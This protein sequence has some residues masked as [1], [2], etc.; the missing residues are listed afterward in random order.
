MNQF[1]LSSIKRWITFLILFLGIF[2]KADATVVIYRDGLMYALEESTKTASVAA[3]SDKKSLV[4]VSIPQ[5]I[6]YEDVEY[7]VT[8][9]G[10]SQSFSNCVN[11]E[12]ISFPSTFT[13]ISGY[14]QFGGCTSLKSVHIDDADTPIEIGW[15]KYSDTD[16]SG[17]FLGC[18]IEELY[19]GRNFYF[20]PNSS[21]KYP[22]TTY[23]ERY[24]Y[25][26]F[27][28]AGM[29]VTLGPKVSRIPDNAFRVNPPH[30]LICLNPSGM[31]IGSESIK[32]ESSN[33]HTLYIPYNTTD[34]Y[35][36]SLSQY[37]ST[38][39]E[40]VYD[41]NVIYIPI[42]ENTC[43]ARQHPINTPEAITIASSVEIDAE[44]Y[45]VVRIADG[46]F[47]DNTNLTS[48]TLPSS[49]KEIGMN[50][51]TNCQKLSAIN[52]N[53]QQIIG[54]GAFKDCTSLVSV[55]LPSSLTDIGYN[56]FYNASSITSISFGDNLKNIGNA[57]FFNCAALT[58]IRLPNTTV[59]IGDNAFTNCQKLTYASL[60]N[61][62]TRIGN[63]AFRNC[64]VLTEIDV[65]GTT[66]T[67]GNG[68]FQDCST[69]ALAT[70]H[71]GLKTM[72]TNTFY[73]CK[74]LS[75]I[76]IPGTVTSIGTGSFDQC[77]ALSSVTFAASDS[78]LTIPSFT[79]APLR[80]LRIGR[81][82]QYTYSDTES[83]FRNKST[84]TRVQFTGNY[85]N[86]I[87]HYLLDGC[88]GIKSITL[89]EN[90]QYIRN[91][92]FRGCSSI[93]EITLPSSLESI[94]GH[95]FDQCT[96]LAKLTVN[97]GSTPL[98]L[99]TDNAMFHDCPIES[100]YMG[101]DIEYSTKDLSLAPFYEQKALTS[102]EI[103]NGPVSKI[104]DGYLYKCKTLPN[105]TIPGSIKTIGKYAFALNDSLKTAIIDSG[106]TLIDDYAFFQNGSLESVTTGDGLQSIGKYAF[107][108][109]TTLTDVELAS[110]LTKIG[111]NSFQSCSSLPSLTMQDAVIS[112]GEYAFAD[113]SLLKTIRLSENLPTIEKGLFSNCTSL[114]DLTIPASIDSIKGLAFDKCTGLAVL[115]FSNSSTPINLASNKSKEG[116]F[117]H[118]P[119]KSLYLGRN[120]IYTADLNNGYSPFSNRTELS[121]VEFSQTGTFTIANDYLLRG[122]SSVKNFR[123]PESLTEIGNYTFSEMDSLEWIEMPNNVAT[124]GIGAFKDDTSLAEVSLSTK[125]TT[126]S[127]ELFSGCSVLDNLLISP[128][129][130]LIDDNVFNSCNSLTT[131]TISDGSEVLTVKQ[132]TDTPKRSMFADSPITN[133]HLGRW[134]T[135]DISAEEYA[136]FYGK[137]TLKNLKFGESVGTIGKYLFERCDSIESIEIPVGVEAIGEQAFMDCSS[138]RS[139]TIGEGLASLGE[140]AFANNVNLDNVTMPSTLN[141]IA[142]G[143]FSH[144]DNLVTLDLNEE[145]EIIGPRAFEYCTSLTSLS[146][147]KNV[148]GLGVESFQG[149]S[150]LTEIIIPD[151]AISSVGARAFKDC[152]KAEWVSLG[153]QV[154]SLGTGSFSGC[155]SIKYIKSYNTTPPVGAPQFAQNVIDHST[156]FVPEES[157]EDYIDS[158]TWWEFFQILPL[159]DAVFITSLKFDQTEGTITDTE[160]LQLHATAGPDTATD[161]TVRYRSSNTSI[162]TVD[163]NGLVTAKSVGEVTITA[164]AADGSGL[165]DTFNL[166]VTP[167]MVRS[168][169]ITAES[170]VVKKGRTL[171]LSAQ[172]IPANATN[173]EVVWSSSNR[174]IATVDADGTV[175][176]IITGTVTITASSTDGSGVKSSFEITVMPPTKG[177]SNDNDQV[178][179][180]DAVN[181]ANYA[182]GNEVETFCFEAADVNGD[183]RIT[184]ADASGTVTEVLNQPAMSAAMNVRTMA[185]SRGFFEMDNLV[186]DDY[187]PETSG[188]VA[189]DVA[190]ENSIDYVALQA[191]ITVPDGME[192]VG[193]E[194]GQRA[195]A[196]HSLMQRRIDD[197]TMRVALFDLD[198]STFA[199]N[200]EPIFR[201]IAKANNEKCGDITISGIIASDSQANEYVLSS[202]GG[203]NSGLAGVDVPFADGQISVVAENKGIT[204][205]NAEG[206]DVYIF[207]VDGTVLA[208]FTADSNAVSRNL[209]NGIYVVAVG[210]TVSK[211]MVK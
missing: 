206:L 181:T 59:S 209:A 131:L 128:S 118:S 146:I 133:L 166:I 124:A 135:Y 114:A 117:F 15:S 23:P 190:L 208:Q 187:T 7:T 51:F 56:A 167:T 125:L 33:T 115:S 122:C 154:T 10:N 173:T 1:T 73:G 80:T 143:C 112:I 132:N 22:Y 75:T 123:L 53:G 79:D 68:A 196:Y 32:K 91:Y 151:G 211:I 162:A 70:L 129:V 48:V 198:N 39:K 172:P 38:V 89:P 189:V 34:I 21:A 97:Y 43:E 188:T 102:I 100:I 12:S 130:T 183:N 147:P 127:K 62:L 165:Y 82:L 204:I 171:S 186:V 63:E 148:Y 37:F 184:L 29:R 5:T 155:S 111:Q 44:T 84:L 149:C 74:D 66:T 58:A 191:D 96:S 52:F 98:T 30:E 47:K 2:Y 76:S 138:L 101:R 158:D 192:L 120:L 139:L 160:T 182:I 94:G 17:V 185:L 28:N 13:K 195:D 142:D 193:V 176:T 116:L 9:L 3:G 81:N 159:T 25:T 145:L 108:Q 163:E 35:G 31:S 71:D 20:D 194:I 202:T 26:P 200:G 24:G 140:R 41:D 144:C 8:G 27:K 210:N 169:D 106:V 19:I 67:I 78:I 57:A 207:A 157:L 92:A 104:N 134:L 16:Y 180:T 49:V 4:N 86:E 88:D 50:A 153:K 54:I 90:L 14:Y 18:P 87:Y 152:D 72:G 197:R 170:S 203:H 85:V 110:T 199:D 60:G 150:L 45:S 178:T 174:G 177:D 141:S 42:G 40:L 61:N 64:S 95:T 65:P 46:A 83:P 164:Y 136:P 77:L 205:F 105:V 201:I 36:T 93:P 156:V 107:A 121:K 119:L 103:A 11:L 113:C 55:S 126:L 137:S 179:I 69:L 109:N 168:I 6:V 99:S 161:N 175:T